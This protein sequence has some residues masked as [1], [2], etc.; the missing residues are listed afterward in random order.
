MP[1]TSDYVLLTVR[2]PQDT[3]ARIRAL[4]AV[5]GLSHREVIV[6][7]LAH[8]HHRAARGVRRGVARELQEHR[9]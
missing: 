7:A 3:C 8:F 4:S 2:L 9:P 5:T 6:A 1:R